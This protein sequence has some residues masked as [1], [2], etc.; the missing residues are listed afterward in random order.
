[1]AFNFLSMFRNVISFKTSI[2]DIG[3]CKKLFGD[4]SHEI[5]DDMTSDDI[6]SLIND[7][8]VEIDFIT[9]ELKKRAV[10]SDSRFKDYL[11]NHSSQKQVNGITITDHAIV[12]YLERG[13]GID[14]NALMQDMLDSGNIT[15]ERMGARTTHTA[16]WF[17]A[18]EKNI[19]IIAYGKHIVTVIPDEKGN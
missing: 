17:S 19:K 3:R 2:R 7:K 11:K 18:P 9:N 16:I 14:V 8:L 10:A 1:M 12:R 15:A 4:L 5:N 6:R 13:M